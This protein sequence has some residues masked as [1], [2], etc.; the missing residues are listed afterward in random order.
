MGK[1]TTKTH[2]RV[3]RLLPS[4]LSEDEW[5][6]VIFALK[7]RFESDSYDLGLDLGSFGRGKIEQ[8]GRSRE[9]RHTSLS[10]VQTTVLLRPYKKGTRMEIS[11]RVGTASTKTESWAYGLPFAMLFAIITGAVLKSTLIG[12]AALVGWTA[13]LVP[14]LYYLDT[15]WREKKHTQ[16]VGLA[17]ELE[18]IVMRNSTEATLS[19]TEKESVSDSVRDTVNDT[20]NE[21]RE[22][23]L[24]WSPEDHAEA[25]ATRTRSRTRS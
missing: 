24:D 3:D 16:L 18:D 22:S 5:E 21:T 4:D 25:D 1:N 17:D 23:Q 13:L 10:G 2:V 9:W 12:S 19:A 7:R 6:E 20:V 8:I 15:K 14:L 11:Q